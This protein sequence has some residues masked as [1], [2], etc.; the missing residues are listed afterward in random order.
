MSGPVASRTPGPWRR[1][2][3][4]VGEWTVTE[5]WDGT[6]RLDGG[7]MWG[8]VPKVLWQR[9][10]PAG[11]DN[12]IPLAL[13][14]FLAERGDQRVL[15][16]GGI[17]DRWTDKECRIY[18]I[19]ASVDLEGALSAC[20]VA[21]DDVTHVVLSHCH[22]D[23]VG[24]LARAADGRLIPRFPRARHFAPRIEVEMAKKSDHAR[25]GSYRP[26]DMRTI[27]DAGLLETY[28][29]DAELFEGVHVHHVGGH[30]DGVSLVTLG[31][32][33]VEPTVVFWTDVVPTTHHIQPPYVMAFDID[34]VRSFE[35][36]SKWI[37][38][39]ADEGWIGLF[40]HDV[41]EAFGRIVR[42]GKRYRLEPIENE[43]I[44]A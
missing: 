33:A 14:S 8:V 12:T 38:R 36:R 9:M 5:L 37:A 2:R 20:G 16:E 41:D 42:D 43:E 19:E 28:E 29:E 25:R 21:A 34:V 27:E 39:A 4:Q 3:I 6:F 35:E 7:A 1:R 44:L 15:I 22:W 24:A 11:V 17:G 26:D 10:T 23:H 40:Y 13:R 31:L 30:S 32:D 18:G